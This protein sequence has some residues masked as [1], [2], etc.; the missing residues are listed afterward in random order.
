MTDFGALSSS[1]PVSMGLIHLSEMS[2]PKKVRKHSG[3]MVNW[4]ET[5]DAV[6]LTVNPGRFAYSRLGLKQALG[7]PCEGSGARSIRWAQSSKVSVTQLKQFGA[8]CSGD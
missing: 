8:F 5:V 6:I 2:G 4:Y 1:N 3:D 7:D